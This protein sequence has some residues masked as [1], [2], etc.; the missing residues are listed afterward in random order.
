MGDLSG[1]AYNENAT[2]SF[3]EKND[4]QVLVG[5]TYETDEQGGEPITYNFGLKYE[6]EEESEK[7]PHL[8][9]IPDNLILESKGP[10]EI[11]KEG[12]FLYQIDAK[13]S[14]LRF[15]S[16]PDSLSIDE[17]S[18]VLSLNTLNFEND[19]YLYYIV[20]DDEYG[21]ERV[22]PLVI[23]VN[24]KKDGA[25]IMQPIPQLTAKVGT[26]YEYQIKLEN[27]QDGPFLFSCDDPLVKID[28]TTGLISFIATQD[29]IGLHSV[30][31]DVQ[32]NKGRTWQ[33]VN[34]VVK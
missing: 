25:G 34:L 14:G 33:R 9:K 11:E 16:V 30:R 24:V 10:W 21:N 12:T 31:I 6:W 26:L 15:K 19:E 28:N 3:Q 27:D 22:M 2:F 17:K 32:N 18:G 20:V 13:G 23:N 5:F 29:D 4:S 7:I 8:G 1:L